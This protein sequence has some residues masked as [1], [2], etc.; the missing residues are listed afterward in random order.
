MILSQ[1][2]QMITRETRKTLKSYSL[3]SHVHAYKI[4]IQ[5][6]YKCECLVVLE[7]YINISMSRT[8]KLWIVDYKLEWD[9]LSV[10]Q[11]VCL[12]RQCCFVA[13][14][15]RLVMNA[16]LLNKLRHGVHVVWCHAVKLWRKPFGHIIML[17]FIW[18]DH[19][20]PC[21]IIPWCDYET[22]GGNFDELLYIINIM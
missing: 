17:F 18:C 7:I 20:N 3:G 19:S 2:C 10:Y 14:F 13:T 11:Y 1:L 21:F 9:C 22:Y 5:C 8:R 6:I 15:K 16:C 12:W 4:V